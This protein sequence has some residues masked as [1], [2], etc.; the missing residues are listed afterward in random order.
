[1]HCASWRATDTSVHTAP[2]CPTWFAPCSSFSEYN[3]LVTK[4]EPRATKIKELQLRDDG[5]HADGLIRAA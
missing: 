1:M 2:A 4:G 5:G 3:V